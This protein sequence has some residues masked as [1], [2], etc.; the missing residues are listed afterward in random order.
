MIGSV[1]LLFRVSYKV[2]LSAGIEA[3]ALAKGAGGAHRSQRDQSGC[4][5]GREAVSPE[6]PALYCML[7]HIRFLL[8]ELVEGIVVCFV[9]T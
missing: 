3:V 6:L 8:S 2:T 9:A 1:V 5:A 4:G 7:P